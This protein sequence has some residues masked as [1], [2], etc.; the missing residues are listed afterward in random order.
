MTK[1]MVTGATGFLGRHLT[2]ELRDEGCQVVAL[3]HEERLDDAFLA[4]GAEVV[5][6]S[7]LDRAA[8]ER[9]AEG[10]E[11]LFHCAG[12]VSRDAKDAGMLH[13]LHVEGT[14]TALD[15]AR[16]KGVK[17]AVVASTSGVVAVSDDSEPIDENGP[18]PL[19]LI[20]SW[21][22]YRSKLFAEN[23]AFERNRDG[24]EV[25]AV[26][27]ALLL[28][29]G[30]VTGSSTGDV[31]EI[32]E[33]RVPVVPGGGL[34]FV[35]ARDAAHALVLAWKKGRPGRRYLVAGQN[36]SFREFASRI[37]RI[38]EVDGPKAELPRSS[39][40]SR[41]GA[42]LSQKLKEHVPGVPAMDR[43]SAEMARTYWYVDSTRA[44]TELGWEPRDPMETLADTIADLRA[45]GILWPNKGRRAF[46]PSS[47]PRVS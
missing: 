34:S 42:D 16:A 46:G 37:A 2:K 39:L 40:L 12:K 9:A 4:L 6:G 41:L 7:V 45:R 30:D 32:V 20:G 27:P 24:F 29:P 10:A 15:G 36:L 17:R 31:I 11:V 22:Y 43:M 23:E 21:P 13:T 3:C 44:R 33:G 47:Q 25:V 14:K 8:V 35:D 1:V 5:K 38:A 26:N 19:E 18:V 28:G